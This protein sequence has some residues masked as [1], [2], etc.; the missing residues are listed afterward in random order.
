V[1]PEYQF[2]TNSFPGHSTVRNYIRY[3]L[4]VGSTFKGSRNYV[5]YKNYQDGKSWTVANL[6]LEHVE[7]RTQQHQRRVRVYHEEESL[8]TMEV[9]LDLG[10]SLS[11]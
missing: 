7:E 8:R 5:P 2:L 6:N 10:F 9:V 1:Q 11:Q 4:T 3:L